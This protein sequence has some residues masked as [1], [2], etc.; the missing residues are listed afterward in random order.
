MKK[1]IALLISM[2]LWAMW[3]FVYQEWFLQYN[4]DY[5]YIMLYGFFSGLTSF[6]VASLMDN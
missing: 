2:L 1:I 4:W 5:P 6:F 3:C